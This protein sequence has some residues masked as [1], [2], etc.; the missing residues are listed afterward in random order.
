MNCPC[1]GSCRLHLGRLKDGPFRECNPVERY[2]TIA[3]VRY[4]LSAGDNADREDIFFPER[5]PTLEAALA[6][7]RTLSDMHRYV[8]DDHPRM[9][10]F[11]AWKG[12]GGPERSVPSSKSEICRA[13]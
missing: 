9:G 8:I 10:T 13:S 1:T 7:V 5:Y 4:L 12:W 3:Q 2:F 6:V 11:P